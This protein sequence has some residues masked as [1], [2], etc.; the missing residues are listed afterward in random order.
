VLI[1]VA[2]NMESRTMRDLDLAVRM[3]EPVMLLIMGAIITFIMLALLM[4]VFQGSDALG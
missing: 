1:N 4:P 3:I 2:D